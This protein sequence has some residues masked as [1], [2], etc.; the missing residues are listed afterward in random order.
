MEN[1]FISRT[2]MRRR[3]HAVVPRTLATPPTWLTRGYNMTLQ[4]GD[5]RQ[6]PCWVQGSIKQSKARLDRSGYLLYRG[7][8]RGQGARKTVARTKGLFNTNFPLIWESSG[9]GWKRPTLQ[10]LGWLLSPSRFLD[11]SAANGLNFWVLLQ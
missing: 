5:A 7:R 11:S 2:I 4:K 9:G 10:V 3:H 1:K 6:E 8:V